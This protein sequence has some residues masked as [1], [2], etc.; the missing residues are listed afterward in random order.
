MLLAE[1]DSSDYDQIQQHL[2][3]SL[4]LLDLDNFSKYRNRITARGWLLTF[5]LY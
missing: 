1:L 2:A 4:V 3:V 5:Y